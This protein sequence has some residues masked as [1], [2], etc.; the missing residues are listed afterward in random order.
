[1][2]QWPSTK[3]RKVLTALEKIGWQV[4]RQTVSQALAGHSLMG[5]SKRLKSGVSKNFERSKKHLGISAV[6]ELPASSYFDSVPP[7]G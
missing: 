4:K 6:F 3:A 7:E 1:M 2:G 5:D